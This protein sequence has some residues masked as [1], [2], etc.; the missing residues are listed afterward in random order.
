MVQYW[1]NKGQETD[2]EMQSILWTERPTGAL[3]GAGSPW[4]TIQLKL[5]PYSVGCWMAHD[6]IAIHSLLFEWL[7]FDAMYSHQYISWISAYA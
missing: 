1:V 3:V 5:A 6:T 4:P 7:T 2:E